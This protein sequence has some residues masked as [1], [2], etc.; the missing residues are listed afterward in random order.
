MTADLPECGTSMFYVPE[1]GPCVMHDLKAFKL[2]H[3]HCKMLQEAITGPGR[4]SGVPGA[5]ERLSS[6]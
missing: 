1:V 3:E 2:S 5:K 4:R 6:K